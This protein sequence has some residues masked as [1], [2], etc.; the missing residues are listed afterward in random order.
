MNKKLYIALLLCSSAL[1]AELVTPTG[2]MKDS[3][4]ALLDQRST[5]TAVL[6]DYRSQANQGDDTDIDMQKRRKQCEDLV[7]KGIELLKKTTL[8][9]ACS[10]MSNSPD[11]VVGEMYLYLFDLK[12]TCLMHGHDEYLIW[13]NIGE[14]KDRY[15]SSIMQNVLTMAETGGGW[16]SY[17]W[18]N[19]T[20]NTYVRRVEK[21]G[22]TYVIGTGFYPH[23]KRASVESMV[24]SAVALFNDSIKKGETASSV[25][26][27]LG[28]QAG[29][30]IFGDLYFFALDFDGKI[31]VQGDLPDLVG[32]SAWDAADEEGK[33]INQ[34]IIKELK[35]KQE[36]EGV[37]LDYKSKRALK[38]AY[39]EKVVDKK[40]KQYFIACG[41]Y[42]DVD[43]KSAVD[44]VRQ[45]FRYLK[46]QGLSEAVKAFNTDRLFRYGNL[47]LQLYTM[48]GVCLANGEHPRLVGNDF[49]N[50]KDDDGKLYMQA[51]INK[52]NEGPGWVDYKERNVFKSVYVE[53]VQLSSESYIITSGLYPSSKRE[54]TILLV[55]TAVDYFKDHAREEALRKF[56]EHEGSF[57]RGDL[58][59]FVIDFNG[60]CLA[61]N[62]DNN[63]IWKNL[64][65]IKDDDGKPFIRLFIN[66]V[67]SGPGQVSF[68]LN[69]APKIAYIEAVEKDGRSYVI[70]SSYYR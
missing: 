50:E 2:M 31:V 12:G 44:L 30:Y 1:V 14:L 26:S 47:S 51:I 4:G 69:N 23:S 10:I 24:K 20:K 37:W 43:R 34:L 38:R 35:Q 66:T 28:Y 65:D 33:K 68:K 7:E 49:Y 3:S 56:V 52:A 54:S 46:S 32:K 45:G 61:Y 58:G 48:Q 22:K 25:F 17:R 63:L 57:I 40:G 36:H 16:T 55:K 19:A 11:Y 60:L 67:K 42:P 15:D 39:A 9:Q 29:P 8:D 27:L 59:I 62:D 6:V 53:K 70:G 5:D 21:D 41:N 13:R 18:R 64:F